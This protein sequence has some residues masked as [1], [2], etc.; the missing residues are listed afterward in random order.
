[1]TPEVNAKLAAMRSVLD[2][3]S[4]EL[5][6][7]AKLAQNLEDTF[8][9]RIWQVYRNLS[10]LKSDLEYLQGEVPAGAK[11]AHKAL[12]KALDIVQRFSKELD[13]VDVLQMV[14]A[15]L[16]KHALSK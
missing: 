16:H 15:A 2:E 9:D 4:P 1:M 7:I 5:P 8:D 14:D 11:D 3:A 12:K 10:G 6:Y 13:D